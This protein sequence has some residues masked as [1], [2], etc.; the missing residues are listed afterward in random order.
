MGNALNIPNMQ[1]D[2]SETYWQSWIFVHFLA[3]VRAYDQTT[4]HLD[5]NLLIE[6]HNQDE[7]WRLQEVM[8]SKSQTMC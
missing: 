3:F 4:K 1:T 8:T 6:W 7:S 5:I 2:E